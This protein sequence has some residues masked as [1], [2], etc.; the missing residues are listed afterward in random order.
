[1]LMSIRLELGRTNDFPDGDKNHGYEFI[2]PLTPDGH[3]D[4]LEWGKHKE[5]CTVRHF[6]RGQD[7]EWGLLRHVGHGW[8]F[9]YDK[10]D[11]RDDERVFKLDRHVI[12]PGLYVS[13]TERDGV[14]RPFKIASVAPVAAGSGAK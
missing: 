13:I 7:E 8:R 1:M 6:R 3:V 12:S 2:A 4:P 14:Q 5:T 9:D 11:D 10:K